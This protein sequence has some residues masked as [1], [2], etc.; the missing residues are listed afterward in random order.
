MRSINELTAREQVLQN[1]AANVVGTIEEK[2]AA[3]EEL[4]V[5]E[6]YKV[7]HQD[8]ADLCSTDIEALKRSL[9][10]FWYSCVEPSCFTGIGYLNSEAVTKTMLTL[11]DYLLN[12]R[13]D[14]ELQWMLSYY[15]SWKFVFEKFQHLESIAELLSNKE[16]NLPASINRLSMEQRG[17]MGKYWNSLNIFNNT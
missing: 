13:A 7:I 15:L 14:K 3:I 4:G 6:A 10:L 2:Y 12:N 8:Y 17:Q 1:L 16:S 11:N 5:F 9:F